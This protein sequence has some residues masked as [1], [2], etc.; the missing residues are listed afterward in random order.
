[1][2]GQPSSRFLVTLVLLLAAG[3]LPA[4]AQ[5]TSTWYD[6]NPSRSNND[7]PNGASGGRV[8]HIGAASDFSRVYA[9][10]E[11][12]GL[13]TSFNQGVEAL[14]TKN[15][16]EAVTQFNAAAANDASQSAVFANLSA[17][18]VTGESSRPVVSSVRVA[19]SGSTRAI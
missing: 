16:E 1:M 5:I 2:R 11:L 14:R 9:A 8:N 19:R 18:S 6:I 10:T 15:C 3:V 12:G 13:Y 17:R 7:N 4:S